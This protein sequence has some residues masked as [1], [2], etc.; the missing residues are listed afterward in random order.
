MKVSVALSTVQNGSM[1]TPADQ[2]DPLVINNRTQWLR[3]NNLSM[4]QATRVHV[5]YD[6]PDF[7][8]YRTVGENDFLDGMSGEAS[9]RADALVTTTPGH[10]LFLPVADCVAATMFD[11]EH[12]VLM[13][14]HLG[15][16]SL[17]Q[18]GGMKSIEYLVEHFN[19]NPK[20]VRVWLSPA[21]SK[22]AYPLF[23]LGNSGMKEAV[24]TQLEQAGVVRSNIIDNPAETDLDD[25]YFSHTAFLKGKKK[26]DGRFAMA[27][28][29][30]VS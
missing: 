17:E 29:M 12:G 21:P 1:Y 4:A 16:H 26:S 9:A 18:Q 30:Q 20:V 28:V 22:R 7:C 14:S 2:N 6:S 10:I 24:F 3:N 8:Q 11:E 5:T 15:R 13:L 25:R 27:A 23:G 19:T